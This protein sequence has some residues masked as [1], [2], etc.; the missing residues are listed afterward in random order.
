MPDD[1]LRVEGLGECPRPHG[2]ET[3]TTRNPGR[4]TRHHVDP[5]HHS[6]C[7]HTHIDAERRKIVR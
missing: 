7:P 1:D 5:F 3:K 6:G 4:E 2:E